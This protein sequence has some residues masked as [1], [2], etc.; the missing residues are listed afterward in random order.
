MCGRYQFTTEES[1]DIK[2]ILHEIE[3][4]YGS[5]AEIKT[6]EIFPTNRVPLLIS[7]DQAIV[8]ELLTWGFP[9]FKNKGVIINARAETAQERPMFRRSF[10]TKRCVIP[11][12]GFFEWDSAKKKHLFTLPDT[13][14]LYMAGLYNEFEGEPRFAILTTTANSS[15]A[16]VH[17]RM[18]LVLSKEKMQ[19]WLTDI[20]TALKILQESQPL[21]ARKAV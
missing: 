2:S 21:L 4:K 11:S 14:T 13:D 20:G 1:E 18:P 16:D 10:Q 15:I 19:G 5:N 17:N 6:G 8:P 9:N 12:T 7:H 3:R